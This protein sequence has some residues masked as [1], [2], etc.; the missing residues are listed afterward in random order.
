M[1]QALVSSRYRITSR[2]GE[3]SLLV[4]QHHERPLLDIR[5]QG[6]SISYID[7]QIRNAVFNGTGHYSTIAKVIFSMLPVNAKGVL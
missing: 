4:P 7:I 6:Q 3:E 1:I 5:L 2:P